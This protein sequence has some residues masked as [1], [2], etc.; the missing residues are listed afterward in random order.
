MR[1]FFPALTLLLLG[2]C[3]YYSSHDTV[4][5]T[6]TTYSHVDTSTETIPTPTPPKEVTTVREVIR[7]SASNCGVYQPPI[8]P[9]RPS[10][11]MAMLKALNESNWRE[12]DRIN[13]EYNKALSDHITTIEKRMADSLKEYKRI[14]PG[15]RK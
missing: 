6:T 5:V 8:L 10:P 14:C 3:A 7:S 1:P 13:V 4:T 11:P 15:F 2:S 12:V 9:P